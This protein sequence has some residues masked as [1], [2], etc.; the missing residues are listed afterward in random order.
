MEI[1]GQLLTFNL[2]VKNM[3]IIA[4]GDIHGHYLEIKK[5]VELV[6]PTDHDT[7]VFVGDYIDRGKQS[8]EVIEYMLELQQT[9]N[10]VFLKGNHEDMFMDYLSG[11]N[12]QLYLDNGGDKTIASYSNHGF[13]I[14]AYSFFENYTFPETHL[15]FFRKLKL[16]YQTDKYIF[17]HGGLFPNGVPVEKQS[18]SMLLWIREPFLN[19]EKDFGKKVIFGHTPMKEPL[20]QDNKIGID[21]GICYGDNLTCVILPE[22]KFMSVPSLD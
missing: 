10:C 3:R 13:D 1:L 16:Y 17:V 2:K 7:L 14:G 15:D 19:S 11:I 20:V 9:Y 18:S 6:K 5:L 4:F 21:T 22:E 8:F 12:N